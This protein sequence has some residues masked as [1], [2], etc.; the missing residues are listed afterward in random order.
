M[1]KT[2]HSFLSKCNKNTHKKDFKDNFIY[3][4]TVC[5]SLDI[6][7]NNSLNTEVQ[8]QNGPK[9]RNFKEKLST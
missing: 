7:Y 1:R 3:K 2:Y 9:K 8:K 4:E 5:F 6:Y